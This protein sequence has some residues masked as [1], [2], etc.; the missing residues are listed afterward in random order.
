MLHAAEMP[1]GLFVVW[2]L[3]T[4]RWTSAQDF[5]AAALIALVCALAGARLGGVA[6][7]RVSAL[8]LLPLMFARGGA[9]LRG[10]LATIRAA[11]AA[12][13]TLKP[14]LV[15]IKTRATLASQRAAFASLLNATPGMALVEADAEGLLIH[16]LNEDA[17]DPNDLGRL[18]R[19]VVGADS[20]RTTE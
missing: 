17:I 3:A 13:V 14:G 6:K 20:I 19:A 9:I 10:A 8:R 5:A 15:R 16:A 7:A 2:L 4:Q 12:D 18:E 1:V 11:A